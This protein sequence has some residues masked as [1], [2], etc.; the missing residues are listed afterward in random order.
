MANRMRAGP[1]DLQD[2]GEVVWM[3]SADGHEGRA[4]VRAGPGDLQDEGEV[5]RMGSADGNEGRAK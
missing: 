5:V 3:G 1:G 4:K 2:E